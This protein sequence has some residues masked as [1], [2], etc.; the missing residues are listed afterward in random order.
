MQTTSVAGMAADEAKQR[1]V[2]PLVY[3]AQPGHVHQLHRQPAAQSQSQSQP[4]STLEWV[5]Q[6]WPARLS[7]GDETSM[8]HPRWLGLGVGGHAIL[9]EHLEDGD[10]HALSKSVV[11]PAHSQTCSDDSSEISGDSSTNASGRS[12]HRHLSYANGE[13]RPLLRGAL[14]DA[15][16]RTLLPFGIG[17]LSTQAFRG[18]ELLVFSLLGKLFSYSASAFLHRSSAT[19]RS[20]RWQR[21]ALQLDQVAICVSIFSSTLP[22]A[23]HTLL[24]FLCAFL[25]SIL[26]SLLLVTIDA[27]RSIKLLLICLAGLNIGFIGF[28]TEGG[29]GNSFMVG[30]TFY[31]LA[32]LCY[33]PAGLRHKNE[34]QT[35]E[36]MFSF[37][38]W[39]RKGVVG[40]HED[41]HTFLLFADTCYFCAALQFANDSV[42]VGLA[43]SPTAAIVAPFQTL[44]MERALTGV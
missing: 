44:S 40:C 6:H 22:F 34:P 9:D 36:A 26:L 32:L 27:G 4:R 31:F 39:H 11:A 14:H 17:W 30:T 2:A 20:I 41:F 10:V 12:K 23:S 5:N 24:P 1:A 13:P 42:G 21:R 8:F 35:A 16:S 18:H 19:A 3:V 43:E 25:V 15:V 29:S 7:M 28:E 33:I 38:P 37:V